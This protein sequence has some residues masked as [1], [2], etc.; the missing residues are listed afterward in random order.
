MTMKIV[1]V[2]PKD[3]DIQTEAGAADAQLQSLKQQQRA[4]K[5]R[6][7]QAKANKALRQLSAIRSANSK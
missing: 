6:L 3:E 5:V 7:A 4:L 2:L 1:E